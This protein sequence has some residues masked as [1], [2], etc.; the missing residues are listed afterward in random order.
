MTG[1]TSL[2]DSAID[3]DSIFIQDI[4]YALRDNPIA[5]SEGS[6][7]AP[8]IQE[9]ALD[10]DCVH[11]AA[12]A[13]ST[14]AGS[15]LVYADD[16]GTYTLTGGTWSW[17]TA[18]CT[19]G[20]GTSIMGWGGGNTAAGTIGLYN[21]SGADR[22]FYVDERY[23]QSSPPYDLGDGEV[24]LFIYVRLENGT[25]KILGVSVAKDPTWAYNG[26]TDITP[27]YIDTETRKRYTRVPVLADTGEALSALKSLNANAYRQ[28]LAGK[29]AIK[30]DL[31]EVTPQFKNSDME[32]CPAPWPVRPGETIAL[33]TPVG[34]M[35]E[36]LRD[37]FEDV[38]P[39]ELV[40][41]INDGYLEV[42]NARFTTL[43]APSALAVH[44]LKWKN[45]IGA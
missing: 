17:W 26:P 30:R 5:I 44:A 25:G 8:K 33:I 29:R 39:K 12:I 6:S 38:G 16:P 43:K 42:D 34:S 37:R 21:M 27:K 22:T 9:A 11:Q 23:I 24:P 14:A 18:G 40:G 4:A 7:G 1:Y 36:S 45:T 13:T 31:I 41:M 3:S 2:S 10:T 32:I 28:A 20:T 35:I 15:L 19:N